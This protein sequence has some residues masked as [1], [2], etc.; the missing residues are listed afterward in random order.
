MAINKIR[1]RCGDYAVVFA[2]NLSEDLRSSC[3]ESDWA[4][5]RVE[6]A[7]IVEVIGYDG[8]EPEDQLLVRDWD[9]LPSALDQA[10]RRGRAAERRATSTHYVRTASFQFQRAKIRAAVSRAL[11]QHH[12][13]AA[14]LPE[15]DKAEN[16][17][18][19]ALRRKG[20]W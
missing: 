2:D 20:L 7:R 14:A 11:A 16:R 9:W 5:V 12:Q 13:R 6:G 15:A 4:L 8:G 17:R 19:V 10:Y 1:L 18:L 3:A